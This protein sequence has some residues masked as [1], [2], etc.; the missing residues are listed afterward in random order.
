MSAV[1]RIS[2]AFAG[3]A[4]R[5][6]NAVV[7]AADSTV[8]VRMTMNNIHVT[9][10][11][12]EG[13][14]VTRAS[15]G[16]LGFKH[17]TRSTPEAAKVIAEQAAQK[18]VAAGHKLSHVHFRGPSRARGQ[19]LLGVVSGGLRVSTVRDVT[20]LPTNGVRPRAARRL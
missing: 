15:G 19:I 9:V 6:A 10:S 5:V 1:P 11:N 3:T 17:R 4:A 12:M 8:H 14:T 2:A 13:G 20:P 18:A 16:M 7:A